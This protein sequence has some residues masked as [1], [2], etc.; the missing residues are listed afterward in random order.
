MKE[1]RSEYPVV[2]SALGIFTTLLCIIILI[3]LPEMALSSF[4]VS[5]SIG[6]SL[7]FSAMIG[8]IVYA[9]S[10]RNE[11][12]LE[13]VGNIEYKLSEKEI[14][15]QIAKRDCERIHDLLHSMAQWVPVV[16]FRYE[17]PGFKDSGQFR[18]IGENIAA[19]TGHR[20]EEVMERPER[21][22]ERLHPEDADT[23]HASLKAAAKDQVNWQQTFRVVTQG[24]A[25]K[26]FKVNASPNDSR[27][28]PFCFDGIFLD[29]TAEHADAANA[30]QATATSVHEPL[31]LA[32]HLN[33]KLQSE[34]A[35]ANAMMLKAEQHK[36]DN[37]E[38]IRNFSHEVRTTVNGTQGMLEMLLDK[39]LDAEQYDCVLEARNTL[40]AL[41]P[42]I[43]D[44][45]DHTYIRAGE[46][47]LEAAPFNPKSLLRET[48]GMFAVEAK[49]SNIK[50]EMIFDQQIPQ[51]LEG[52]AGRIRQ[53]LFSLLN[54]AVRHTRTGTVTTEFFCS[55]RAGKYTFLRVH[56]KDPGSGM[57]PEV[58][59]A[60]FKHSAVLNRASGRSLG[61][62]LCRNLIELMGGKLSVKSDIGRGSDVYFVLRLKD[63]S[64]RYI[65]ASST[66]DG[67]ACFQP[68][69]I[70]AA[71]DVLVN[72]KICRYRVEA[73]GHKV[74]IVENGQRALE[75]LANDTFDAV[76]MDCEMPIMD[77]FEATAAIRDN[78]YPVKN[79]GIYI[80]AVTA[81]ALRGD[82]GSILESGMNEYL[83]KPFSQEDIE[84]AMHRVVSY[85]RE[86]G[87][88]FA[89]PQQQ[90]A[91][92]EEGNRRTPMHH[93]SVSSDRSVCNPRV[94]SLSSRIQ[95]NEAEALLALTSGKSSQ[96]TAKDQ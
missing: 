14:A 70:L 81:K 26:Y 80:V 16:L 2:P 13:G 59:E 1:R 42:I 40:R 27:D 5:L 28:R 58:Q 67:T 34:V 23:F 8:Y 18:F 9:L 52:D 50:L 74:T 93:R 38:L 71:E 6:C 49:Q 62:H 89:L 10:K 33:A 44:L 88:D 25:T 30:E 65:E 90:I 66:P 39:H 55:G 76:L 4:F 22:F 3:D 78:D 87:I 41:L 47:D 64:E 54:N 63:V 37:A 86:H 75:A 73:L 82:R 35:R 31:E 92:G 53:I 85:N 32:H 7:L 77:G 79:P 46:L 95:K 60:F 61:L 15:Y 51:L 29:V 19:V 83:S 11:A 45:I 56:V 57:Q 91:K 43:G 24:G 84:G 48:V 21:F 12:L 96:P 36:A 69:N 94:G 72:Q 68:L 20:A 17:V